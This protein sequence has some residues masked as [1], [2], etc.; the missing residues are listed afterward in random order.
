MPRL[1]VLEGMPGE[2]V[3]KICSYLDWH[4][5][6]NLT[7]TC[8]RL[9]RLCV[10]HLHAVVTVH[11]SEKGFRRLFSIAQSQHAKHVKRFDYLVPCF[12]IRG[13]SPRTYS[14]VSCTDA[15][16]D[17]GHLSPSTNSYLPS[18]I[19]ELDEQDEIVR[20]GEDFQ[21]LKLA[22]AAFTSLQKVRILRDK[23]R[24][25]LLFRSCIRQ[26]IREAAQ[27]IELRWAPALSHSLKTFITALI[28]ARSPCTLFSVPSLIPQ[29]TIFA[30]L[31]QTPL[32][33]QGGFK[34]K[35]FEAP[36]GKTITSLHS[37]GSDGERNEESD[38]DSYEESDEE[39]DERN[40]YVGWYK[41]NPRSFKRY[42]RSHERYVVGQRAMD[43]ED[44]YLGV[45][46]WESVS[47]AKVSI[48]K[49]GPHT[50]SD[51]SVKKNYVI[52][53]WHTPE[54]NRVCWSLRRMDDASKLERKMRSR[55]W[56]LE[57]EHDAR[58][59]ANDQASTDWSPA[60]LE[61]IEKLE[62]ELKETRTWVLE[63]GQPDTP[64]R[65]LNNA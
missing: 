61:E 64:A 27:H 23:D 63:E 28:S 11:F 16:P 14:S 47:V 30:P 46:R 56:V 3:D 58:L 52:Q 4:S 24:D 19:K 49:G 42:H 57:M 54:L 62:M 12:P 18:F 41:N 35:R 33:P 2:F 26:N 8:H 31:A 40:P 1:S 32:G 51:E 37:Q 43:I 22:L 45:I 20:S 7:S 44:V 9:N 38:G 21:T 39:S 59:G 17:G 48:T 13:L 25:N 53:K 55:H 6:A 34:T 36:S 29:T 65:M 15:K 60:L 5:L 50:K 10:S